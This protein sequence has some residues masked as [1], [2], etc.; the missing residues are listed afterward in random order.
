MTLSLRRSRNQGE[1]SAQSA[2]FPK[3]LF[4][5]N[6]KQNDHPTTTRGY[7]VYRTAAPKYIMRFSFGRAIAGYDCYEN[8]HHM[9][10][11]F[12]W[13]DKPP[14]TKAEIHA[15]VAES[16]KAWQ[17]LVDSYQSEH[18]HVAPDLLEQ[19]LLNR[20]VIGYDANAERPQSQGEQSSP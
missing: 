8:E 18:D 16:S 10:Y 7:W 5:S 11:C 2:G 17:Q 9:F 6:I 20:G 14:S 19:I 4:S 3:F 1:I 13:I 15:L 12:D